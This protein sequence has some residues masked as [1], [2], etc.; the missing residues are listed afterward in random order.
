MGIY[1]KVHLIMKAVNSKIGKFILKETMGSNLVITINDRT[2]KLEYKLTE[3]ALQVLEKR[4]LLKDKEGNIVE[5]PEQLWRR[6][7]KYV[8]KAEKTNELREKW[9]ELF[10][11]ALHTTEF[12]SGGALIFAGL[13]E[14]AVFS[15]CLVLPVKDSIDSIFDTLNMNIEMLK[16]GV[17]TGFNF[18]DIRSSYSKVSTTGEYAS[19]PIS[20]LELYNKAQD[21]VVGRGGRGLGSMAILNVDHPNIEKF[22]HLKNDLNA[23]HHYNISAGISDRFMSA[24]RNDKDWDLIDPHDK[25]TYKTIRA[26]ELFKS[27]SE[28]AWK[29]GDPGLFFLDTA[30]KGNTT[31][32]LGK[33]DG[34]NPCGE[35]PLI[36]YETCNLGNID[37]SKMIRGNPYLEDEKLVDLALE[38]KLNLVN[39]KKLARVTKIGIRFLD[40]IIDV[41]NY[42]VRE[43]G[44]VTRKTRNVGLGIMG[45]ADFLV[46]LA[47]SYDSKDAIQISEEVM[48]FIQKEAHKYSEKLGKEKGSFPAFKKSTWKTKGKRKYMRNTRTTTIAPTGTVSIIADCNPGIEP[49]FALGYTRKNSLGGADQVVV[50]H[51]FIEI[52]KKRGFYSDELENEI[53]KGKHLSEI[54]EKY[55]IP[56]D[57]V[58]IFKTTHEIDSKQHV[59][60]QAA[61]QK[62]VDSAVSKTINLP[63]TASVRDIEE[64]YMLAY[65]LGC[66]GITV[67]RDGS[68]DPALQV[69]LS[70][71]N[72]DG[73]EEIQLV[74]VQS[75]NREDVVEGK[76]FKVRTEQGS[77]F[78]TINEDDKGIVEIFLNVGKSGS[79]TAGYTEAI[80]RLLSVALRSGISAKSVVDQLKGIRVSTPTINKGMIIYSVPDAIAKVLENYLTNGKDQ[81]VMFD[82]QKENLG[83]V[84]DENKKDY[85][86]ENTAGD[87]LECPDCHGDLI[88]AEGCVLCK[89]CG[90]SKC[91]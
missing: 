2:E 79:Y 71:N 83:K 41:N 81:V 68:K 17:G 63:N 37:I 28:H 35:Q 89:S 39:W 77:L 66:K 78:V 88:Y 21:T 6:I 57:V 85:T 45:L 3:N 80:G 73:K 34:T 19:G 64:A 15:K 20:F 84:E 67:F 74:N 55:S 8:A 16:R 10:F 43:V 90:Y 30:E 29:S 25:V 13:G 49:I 61:F 33:M 72:D 56:E 42:P 26:K 12:Q 91:G 23:I 76:T 47:I 50:E 40:N 1:K 58:S 51:L 59:R 87:L 18:S 52:A 27:I 86:K 4:A 32:T 60:M 62:H 11:K 65:E 48:E 70:K 46:K 36:P 53:A 7:A 9:E 75:R 31:P 22:I 69:G 5:N 54:K 82:N 44:V 14:H 38:E 24:V